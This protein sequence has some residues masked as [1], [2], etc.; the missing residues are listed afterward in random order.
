LAGAV[1]GVAA[2]FALSRLVG[3][4]LFQVSPYNSAIATSAVCMLI[5][6]GAT[7]CLVPARRAA[8]VDP[9]QALRR[10]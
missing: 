1:A 10:E 4:L 8:A 3:S 2:A 7:A 6:M 9:M 5:A